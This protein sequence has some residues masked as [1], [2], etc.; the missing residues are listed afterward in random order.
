MRKPADGSREAESIVV[1][2]TRT[3]L[4][5]VTAEARS[6]SW[7]TPTPARQAGRATW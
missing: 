2:E 3:Y 1:L 4:K 6:R 7:T 5:A